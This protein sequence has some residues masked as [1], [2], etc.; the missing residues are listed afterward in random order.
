MKNLF[1]VSFLTFCITSQ[2]Q[3]RQI[4][5]E[6]GDLASVLA[7]A[8]QENKLI[9]IDAYTT[10]CGP[11]KWLA[12][13]VFT[14]DTVADYFNANFVNYKMDM[15]KGEGI[16]FAQKY[17]VSCYPNLI[18]INGNGELIHRGAGGM[19]AAMI[20]DFAK[21]GQNPS[22]SFSALKTSFEKD[23]LNENN[24]FAYANLLSGSCLD[25]S[26]E[27][28]KYLKG[29][30]DE[31]LEKRNN[32]ILVRDYNNDHESREI[33]Y[34]FAHY[35]NFESKFGKDT[36][37][38]KVVELG[39]SYFAKYTN[40]SAYDKT[41]FENAKKEFTSLN[42]PKSKEVIFNAE[43]QVYDRFD[44]KKYFELANTDFLNYNYN[45]PGALNSMAWQFY[46]KV[47]DKK[48][49]A[50]AVKMAERANVLMPGNYAFL[51]THAAVLYKSG[52]NKEAES[53][54]VKAIDTAK[55]QK[56]GAEEYKETEELLKKIRANSK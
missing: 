19:P 55:N 29:V 53:I 49:L 12:K 5:F 38:S 52:N 46:E 2:A 40:S 56:M 54:A 51:D 20:I 32:W 15:E 1:F 50:S 8:K 14:N 18:F 42:W 13:N 24:V 26:P 17:S 33:K 23:G 31:D 22:T 44:S 4:N 30:K 16:A 28:K 9:F 21:A 36:L 34:L 6:H 43:L 7:K 27:I 37:E 48:M 11:C 3:N 35:K 25:P 10:W 39:R 45:N 41:G 47:E